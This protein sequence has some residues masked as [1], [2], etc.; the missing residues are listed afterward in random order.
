[1]WVEVDTP[2]VWVVSTVGVDVSEVEVVVGGT[3]TTVVLV[4]R[5]LV[6]DEEDEVRRPTGVWVAPPT[7][8][9]PTAGVDAPPEVVGVTS[10]E[11]DP[12]GSRS[13]SRFPRP[14]RLEGLFLRIPPS[15]ITRDIPFR[16][17]FGDKVFRCNSVR[18]RMEEMS[19]GEHDTT[20][21]VVRVYAPKG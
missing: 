7:L 13:W 3:S 8:I 11:D 10:L 21:S 1:M 14:S 6:V 17:A 9:D 12:E 2:P 18:A 4:E 20:T 5:L 16:L 19:L 15:I